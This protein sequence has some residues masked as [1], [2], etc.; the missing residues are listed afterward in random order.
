VTEALA[1]MSSLRLRRCAVDARV[2]RRLRHSQLKMRMTETARPMTIDGPNLNF[3]RHTRT[4]IS[5]STN[6]GLCRG[7]STSAG[8][9]V[10]ALRSPTP[11]PV[12]LPSGPGIIS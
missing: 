7:D 5:G 3:S 11:F 10:L 8:S 6:P 1:T 12:T 2:P 9:C 4:R